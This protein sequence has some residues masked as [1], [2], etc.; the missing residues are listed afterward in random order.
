MKKFLLILLAAVSVLSGCAGYKQISLEDVQ[1][2]NFKMSALTYADVTLALQV[3]NPTKAA[4]K[5][6]GA[7]GVVY[8]DGVEFARI[9][10]VKDGIA[11]IEPGVLPI[12]SLASF[13]TARTSFVFESCCESSL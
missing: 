9:S 5:I 13:P 10:Q 8:K 2:K 1:M 6:D 7:E 3:N 11:V 4:F 12:I